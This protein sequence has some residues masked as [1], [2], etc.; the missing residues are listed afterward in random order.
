[1]QNAKH[2][3]DVPINLPEVEDSFAKILFDNEDS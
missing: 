3:K 1:M 2:L